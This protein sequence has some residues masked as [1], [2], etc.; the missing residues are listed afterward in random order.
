MSRSKMLLVGCACV[1]VALIAGIF[2]PPSRVGE[3]TERWELAG[4]TFK[5]RVSRHS[6][7]G[8]R[9]VGGAYYVFESAAAGSESWAEIMRVR[10]D[11]PVEIPREQV[12][13]VNER[14]GYAFMRYN[15]AV[16]TDGGVTWSVWDATEDLPHWRRTRANINEVQLAPDG[17]GTMRLTSSTN[18]EVPELHTG[19]YGRTWSAK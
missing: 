1:V 12:R 15:Y 2:F 18:Q 4:K 3:L 6:E 13:F 19:D 9:L 14:V 10:H 11:D 17:T 5:I 16:T 8:F 7:R